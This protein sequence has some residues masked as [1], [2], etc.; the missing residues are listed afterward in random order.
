MIFVTVGEQLPFDRLVRAFDQWAGLSREEV[1]AQ[2]GKSSYPPT[3][4]QYKQ[5]LDSDEF[6]A[7]LAEADAI[8][9]HAGMGTIISALEIGKP[10]LVMPRRAFLGE[11]RNDHQVAT[12][13]RF[14][15]V[16]AI[17]VAMDEGEL[18]EKLDRINEAGPPRSAARAERVASQELI[19][20]IRSFISC[21]PKG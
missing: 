19:E 10:I 15:Q 3:Y 20:A 2:I 4:I 17:A 9:A 7:R 6:K 12:A 11:V 16:Y 8:V 21:E 13:K 18:L 1:F 5:F 14:S